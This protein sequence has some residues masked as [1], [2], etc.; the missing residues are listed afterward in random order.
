MFASLLFMKSLE[1]RR[2]KR[3]R[4][5]RKPSLHLECLEDR[6]LLSRLTIV[7]ETGGSE[8][9]ISG[10]EAGGDPVSL[11]HPDPFYMD[12]IFHPATGVYVPN[13]GRADARVGRSSVLY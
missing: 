4:D 3:N 5:R 12:P 6:T 7:S 1:G 13:Y 10:T 9:S 11:G 8:W 2:L